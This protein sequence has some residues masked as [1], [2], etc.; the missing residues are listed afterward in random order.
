MNN[1]S[2][3]LAVVLCLPAFLTFAS[4]RSRTCI[5]SDLSRLIMLG[6]CCD[7]YRCC[8]VATAYNEPN[9]NAGANRFVKQFEEF[10]KPCN[11]T[12]C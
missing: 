1:P 5:L 9:C 11:A 3:L 10:E 6:H 12:S 8:C 4:A 2:T 7:L